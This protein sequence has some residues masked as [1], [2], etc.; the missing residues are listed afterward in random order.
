MRPLRCVPVADWSGRV[1]A[2]AAS[3]CGRGRAGGSGDVRNGRIRHPA[4]PFGLRTIP[5]E[6]ANPAV[7]ATNTI[8]MPI[9]DCDSHVDLRTN[10]DGMQ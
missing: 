10:S 3:D 9:A 7:L 1:C 6:K 8:I 4:A 5:R 2:T